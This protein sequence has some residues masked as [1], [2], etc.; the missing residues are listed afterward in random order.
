M[1]K[2]GKI[3]SPSAAEEFMHAAIDMGYEAETLDEGCCGIGTFILW[4][5]DANHYSFFV[6]EVYLN[7]WSSGQTV[8]R[9]QKEEN[10]PPD[11]RKLIETLRKRN[12]EQEEHECAI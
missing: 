9:F 6:Q 8:Q 7:C 2:S 1:R 10:L 5:P 3:Y 12:A 11:I 4:S